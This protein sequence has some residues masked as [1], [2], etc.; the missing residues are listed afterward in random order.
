MP[1]VPRQDS[2]LGKSRPPSPGPDPPR[3]QPLRS[4]GPLPPPP[5]G[6][7]RRPRPSAPCRRTASARVA[8]ALQIPRAPRL[9]GRPPPDPRSLRLPP[10]HDAVPPV[11]DAPGGGG[12]RAPLRRLPGRLRH[13][14]LRPDPRAGAVRGGVVRPD[15]RPAGPAVSTDWSAGRRPRRRRGGVG[16]GNQVR[17]P[18]ADADPTVPQLLPG[19]AT[20]AGR[21]PLPP[22]A[23]TRRLARG[24]LPQRA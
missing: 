20:R 13:A 3:P 1:A 17:H 11:R 14:G 4:P 22:P 19:R 16:P 24:P 21:L 12:Q 18:R 15:P 6:H 8:P 10:V 23:G 7:G 5:R 9:A 2:T